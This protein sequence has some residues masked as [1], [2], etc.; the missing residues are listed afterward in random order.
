MNLKLEKTHNKLKE[1]QK[2]TNYRGAEA[3]MK[4]EKLFFNNF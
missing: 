1:R 2:N 3:L 4:V